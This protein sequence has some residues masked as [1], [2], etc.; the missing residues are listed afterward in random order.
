MAQVSKINMGGIDYDIRDKVLEKEVANIKPIVNQG[1]INNAA[2][3]ED[4]TS[5]NNLLKLK[6]RSALNGMGYVIL[7][8]NKTFAEQ[9]THPNTM[10]EIRY[11]FDLNGFSFEVPSGCY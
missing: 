7:R 2:D 11:D 8:K 5:E 9:V 4:L 6:D 10:Y 3:E 1:T